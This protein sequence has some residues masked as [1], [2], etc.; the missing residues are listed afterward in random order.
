MKIKFPN[1]ITVNIRPIVPTIINNNIPKVPDLNDE[2]CIT[3]KYYGKGCLDGGD[4]DHDFVCDFYKR[5]R[6]GA[7]RRK[8]AKYNKEGRKADHEDKKL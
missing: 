1:G 8:R 6:S 2:V 5:K 3:C 7:Y 4:Q